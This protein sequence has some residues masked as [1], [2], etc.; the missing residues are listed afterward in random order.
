[1]N[2]LQY[3]SKET[4]DQWIHTLLTL[5]DT[6]SAVRFRIG[7]FQNGGSDWAGLDE[8][9]LFFDSE[10]DFQAPNALEASIIND[11]QILVTFDEPLLEG[12]VS[13]VDY[14]VSSTD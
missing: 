9:S 13:L 4:D 12:S 2:F 10:A 11:Q 1:M 14:S 8:F 7:G 3:L 6:V 5:P